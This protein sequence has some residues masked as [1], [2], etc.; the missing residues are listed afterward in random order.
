VDRKNW[1][2]SDLLPLLV[3]S[4]EHPFWELRSFSVSCDLFVISN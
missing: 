2:N 4:T 3:F 1:N